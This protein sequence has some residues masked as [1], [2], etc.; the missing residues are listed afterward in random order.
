MAQ[1]ADTL[2]KL[3]CPTLG[4]RTRTVMVERGMGRHVAPDVLAD[5]G[6]IARRLVALPNA[7]D[8]VGAMLLRHALW[9][10]Q[11]RAGD[12]VA[13]T[14]VL[15]Q[16]ISR[17]AR[18]YIAAG[19]NAMQM[20]AGLLRAADAAGEALGAQAQ[21]LDF[22][23]GAMR[24]WVSAQCDDSVLA[25]ALAEVL[26]SSGADV[27]VQVDKAHS[28]GITW[29]FMRGA[30][31]RTGWHASP[32]AP[33]EHAYSQNLMLRMPNARV[34][35]SDLDLSDPCHMEPLLMAMVR[36]KPARLLVV[37]RQA[38]PQM[39]A[40]FVQARQ[41]GLGD[42]VF[43]KP[44]A[45]SGPDRAALLTDMAMLTGATFIPN[46]EGMHGSGSAVNLETLL[47]GCLGQADVA[48]A[49][50]QFMGI[51][52]GESGGDR[53]AQM[54]YLRRL[55]EA[56]V[57]E[58]DPARV[59]FYQARMA[60]FGSGVIRL[61]I[62]G[63]TEAEQTRRCAQ[64]ERITRLAAQ[65]NRYGVVPG[66]GKALLLCEPAVQKVIAGLEHADA[67]FGA[68]CLARALASPMRAIAHNAGLD[69]AA[70]EQRNRTCRRGWAVDVLRDKTVD[71]RAAGIVDSAFA[72]QLAV[73]TAASAASMFM[74]TDVIVHRRQTETALRP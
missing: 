23:N 65:V 6:T 12:A 2:V 9:R 19:G 67:R 62:G 42:A 68:E 36:L 17:H 39:L 16:A 43:V 3:I 57:A 58:D 33:G 5:A 66:A 61:M 59:R 34:L 28:V 27:T 22:Q 11:E 51:E 52:A 35:V 14:A 46:V 71:L 49:S 60:T 31:W 15:F 74:T 10:V 53:T 69:G 45:S 50:E 25:D 73:R 44:P 38:S 70:V 30:L 47:P 29:E 32:F 20:R 24:R 4:P 72:L 26:S 40:L 7:D 21:P 56:C 64:A 37:C 18:A 13:T 63:P 48:W 54:D 1:G 41:Q 55:D 8:D